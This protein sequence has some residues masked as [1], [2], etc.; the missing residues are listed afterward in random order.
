[1]SEQAITYSQRGRGADS[2]AETMAEG[3]AWFSLALG[4]VQLFA[5][6]TITRSL[7]MQG[8][9]ALVRAYGA[10]EISK[11]FGILM[12]RDRAPWLWARVAGD[13]LDIGTLIKAYRQDNPRKDNVA[14]ALVNVA[15][16]TALDVYCAQRLSR[17]AQQRQRQRSLIP[18]YSDRSGFPR[19]PREM[20]G[21]AADFEVPADM[22]TPE[23]LRPYATS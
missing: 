18:D 8:Q 21:A 14:L 19:P 5:P 15:A 9:E 7:G 13:A 10:R 3:L 17:A 2:G 22:R 23:A 20:R 1:M 6:Q 4:S 11:G 12:F 16:V